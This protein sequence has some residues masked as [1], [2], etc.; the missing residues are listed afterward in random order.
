[1]NDGNVRIGSGDRELV[2]REV[3]EPNFEYLMVKLEGFLVIMQLF[4]KK[5]HI[6]LNL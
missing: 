4:I 5:R 3:F 6:I 1:M 2:I